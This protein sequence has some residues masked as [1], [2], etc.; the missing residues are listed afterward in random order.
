MSIRVAII[1]DDARL[2]ASMKEMLA[3]DR[4][5]ECVAVYADAESALAQL[6]RHR[7][8]V[9]LADIN[10]P[11]MDGIECVRRL[12][13]QMPDT[14]F[15]VITVYQDTQRIFDALAAGASGYLAKPVQGEQL[16]ASI[17]DVVSGG[18]PLT[19]VIA[20]Q[21]IERFRPS[22]SNPVVR[23]NAEE[24]LTAREQEVLELL[25]QGLLYKQVGL[26]LGMTINTVMSH[27]RHIYK[28]LQVHSRREAIEKVSRR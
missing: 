15:I 25:V 5:C 21:I 6:P 2:R 18:A 14:Q 22:A 20:R 1:E 8:D 3:E 10:L 28:K 23:T 4:E 11:R 9:V 19:G 17:R 24:M 27:I 13:P 16:L 26:R 7:P 12:S